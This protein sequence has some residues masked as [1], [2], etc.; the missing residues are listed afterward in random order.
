M[1]TVDNRNSS[2]DTDFFG[3]GLL[4]GSISFIASKKKLHWT[5]LSKEDF[6]LVIAVGER[7]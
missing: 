4:F 1:I 3:G 2:S 6:V 7:N 5:T